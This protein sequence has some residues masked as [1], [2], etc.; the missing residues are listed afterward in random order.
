MQ[1]AIATDLCMIGA[2]HRA[3]VVPDQ[4]IAGLPGVAEPSAGADRVAIEELNNAL[5]L[6]VGYA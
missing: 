6:R 2:V 3:A 5:C 4:D 1:H